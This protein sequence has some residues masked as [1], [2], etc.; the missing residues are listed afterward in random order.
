VADIA[1]AT[2]VGAGAA[3]A[4]EAIAVSTAKTPRAFALNL[5]TKVF[6]EKE[7]EL[8]DVSVIGSLY[9]SL[10]RPETLVL[11]VTACGRENLLHESCT[12]RIYGLAT[13]QAVWDAGRS[14][15]SNYGRDFD[16]TECAR[17]FALV[18]TKG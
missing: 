18:I 13:Y 16:A 6:T 5:P 10:L 9:G 4:A 17:L 2:W 7:G 1:K 14:E 15:S 12:N 3:K 8:W 11:T